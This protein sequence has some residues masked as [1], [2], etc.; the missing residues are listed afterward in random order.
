MGEFG[1]I[2]DKDFTHIDFCSSFVLLRIV[3][4][5]SFVRTKNNAYVFQT[6]K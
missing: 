2:T 5:D 4:R 3:V 6:E 1:E